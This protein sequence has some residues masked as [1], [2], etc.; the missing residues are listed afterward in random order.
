MLQQC[1]AL[2][3][4]KGIRMYELKIDYKGNNL[5]NENQLMDKMVDN[6]LNL[7]RT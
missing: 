2:S 5:S 4:F 6:L 3:G 7:I 1:I